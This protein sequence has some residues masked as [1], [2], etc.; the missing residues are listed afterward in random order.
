L[1]FTLPDERLHPA[2]G[3]TAHQM[4]GGKE[5]QYELNVANSLWG[6]KGFAIQPAFLELT[7]KNYAGGFRELD[8]KA[9]PEAA[10]GT[11]NRWVEEKTRNRIQDLLKQGTVNR[12]T[13][14]VLANALYFK[15]QW[16]QQFDV[17]LTADDKFRVAPDRTAPVR[18]MMQ[19]G[20]FSYGETDDAQLLGMPYRSGQDFGLSMVV[21]LPKTIDGLGQLEAKL[22]GPLLQKW[23]ALMS[24]RP[25]EI[26][27]PK[28]K[29]ECDYGLVP[30]LSELKMQTAFDPTKADF[31][32][33]TAEREFFIQE[34]VHKAMIEVNEEGTVAA[35]ATA[36]GGAQ[37]A[38]AP[39]EPFTFRADHPF[40][41]AIVARPSGNVLF[42]GRF[43]N[44]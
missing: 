17:R 34:V 36:V 24:G 4:K 1:H 7:K 30:H 12:Q 5:K 21:I 6:Q 37:P 2:F 16:A 9:D 28:F 44:P 23:L 22:S 8:F 15:G 41:Y 18:M 10:R 31:T 33:I 25:G 19:R 3:A 29:L 20:K 14:L 42:L 32:A 27:F 13:R 38:S 35:A 39:P 43:V 26:F 40:L 11:I